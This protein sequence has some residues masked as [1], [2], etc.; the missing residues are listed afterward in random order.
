MV[1]R[2]QSKVVPQEVREYLHKIG[3]GQDRPWGTFWSRLYRKHGSLA[4]EFKEA[5]ESRVAGAR[6]DV[7]SLM[8]RSLQFSLDV[9]SQYSGDFYRNYLIWF[10][11]LD[12]N[13]RHVIDLGCGNGLLTCVYASQFPNS[14]VIGVDRC[15]AAISCAQELTDKLDLR[16]VSF[17]QMDLEKEPSA[18]DGTYDLVLATLSLKETAELQ[19]E[20]SFS[21]FDF[22][23]S[24]P[25]AKRIVPRLLATNG[26]F[27]SV[28]RWGG[29]G[30]LAWWVKSLN[31]AELS[32]EWQHS[33][34]MTFQAVGEQETLPA[35]IAT[36]KRPP[37]SSTD[38]DIMAFRIAQE[39][40][41]LHPVYENLVAEAFF[42]AMNPKR[43]VRG[44]EAVFRNGSGIERFE[45][46][47]A[48]SL[49][50]AYSYSNHGSRRLGLASK[51]ALSDVEKLI[52]AFGTEKSAY[53]DVRF[54]A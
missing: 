36:N 21:S 8:H 3:I 46:W 22:E 26:H 12:L 54:Y 43:L 11:T 4:T 5:I 30:D 2:D 44:V 29:L 24:C 35:L 14:T 31:E 33:S 42:H 47:I 37:D 52:E 38:Q 40:T 19:N 28:E 51:V 45:L 9:S 10:A 16:N 17:K 34:L 23:G 53:A 39:L 25:T 15:A 32:I 18:L 49:L 1:T 41:R 13:P 7:Y 50:L 27:V 20:P 6:I 48:E